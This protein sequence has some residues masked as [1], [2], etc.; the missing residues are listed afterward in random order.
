MSKDLIAKIK[1]AEAEAEKIRADAAEEAKERIRRAEAEAALFCENAEKE[2]ERENAK[3]LGL[4]RE[5]ADELLERSAE[6]AKEEA[7]EIRVAASPYTKEA[8]RLV[9]EGVWKLCQ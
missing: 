6:T 8:V 9:T 2:A 1:E 7:R 4:T 5:K 3:K